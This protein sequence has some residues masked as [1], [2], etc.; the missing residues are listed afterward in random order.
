[1]IKFYTAEFEAASE[2]DQEPNSSEAKNS[3]AANE[4]CLFSEY[5]YTYSRL[6]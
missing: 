2:C 6:F 3:R 5:V 4:C 1:M